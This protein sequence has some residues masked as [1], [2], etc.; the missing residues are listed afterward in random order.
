MMKLLR[1]KAWQV[2]DVDHHPAVLGAPLGQDG[3]AAMGVTVDVGLKTM[4][5][6]SLSELVDSSPEFKEALIQRALDDPDGTAP[7]EHA[8]L[9]RRNLTVPLAVHVKEDLMKTPIA[10]PMHPS[11]LT[12]RIPDEK[13]QMLDDEFFRANPTSAELLD[14]VTE[15]VPGADRHVAAK[16]EWKREVRNAAAERLG[17]R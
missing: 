1:E 14:L 8:D 9:L 16:D 4:P 17:G 11:A 5:T 12:P 3:G 13:L 6:I 2:E 15:G 7:V 10:T